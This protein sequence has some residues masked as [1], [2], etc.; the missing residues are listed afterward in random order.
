M[1]LGWGNI[2]KIKIL[3]INLTER[4]RERA[5]VGRV[6]GKGRGRSRLPPEQEPNVGFER[7]TLGS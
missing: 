4:E 3:F 6:T 5:Q 7:R 2:K 1:P